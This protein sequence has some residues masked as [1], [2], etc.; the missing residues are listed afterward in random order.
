MKK[1]FFVFTLFLL[2]EIIHAGK[3]DGIY[4]G[5]GVGANIAS[6]KEKSMTD[7]FKQFGANGKIYAGIGKSLLDTIFIGAEG[8]A[9]YSF[10]VKKE[11]VKKDNLEGA[12]QFGGY[13]KA[14]LRPTENLLFYGLYGAQTNATKIKTAVG[15]ILE[16]E[17]HTWTS[18]IGLGCEYAFGLGTAI[19]MEGLYEPENT[20]KIKDVP[21]I[22][23][24]TSYFSITFGLVVYL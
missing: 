16:P 17:D 1:Y 14:G 9:R 19:R 20:F 11:D 7:S 2:T 4:L 21:T 12:S 6:L 22:E 10:F 23:Y 15:N 8:F 3:F 24:D 5:A 13:L 18:V